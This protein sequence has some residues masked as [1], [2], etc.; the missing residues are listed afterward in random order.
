MD[1]QLSRKIYQE[2]INGKMI[3]KYVQ[4]DGTRSENR[5]YTELMLTYNLTRYREL[6]SAI[7]YELK[8][9]GDAFFLNEVDGDDAISE[10]AMKIQALIIVMARGITMLRGRTEA[11]LE[12]AAGLPREQIEQI[13]EDDEVQQ[14]LRAASLGRVSLLNDVE[15]VLV[16]RQVAY[17]NTRDRLVLTDGGVALYEHMNALEE[18]DHWEVREEA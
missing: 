12:D 8:T 6:Y 15:T 10:V 9:L 18:V 4:R 17:W 3:N 11:L 2:L 13:G 1:K 16:V 5:L 7:G 14:V